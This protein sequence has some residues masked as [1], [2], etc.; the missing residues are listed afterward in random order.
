MSQHHA[1][2][3]PALA[4]RR[5]QRAA[6]PGWRLGL[7]RHRLPLLFLLPA[8]V[9]VAAVS[10]YPIL[11]AIYVS[12]HETSYLRLT[13]F[14]GLKHYVDFVQDPAGQNNLLRSFIYVLGSLVL[15]MPL[16]VSVAILLNRRLRFRTL[17]RTVVVIPWVIAQ[18][19]AALTWGWLANGQFGPLPFLMQQLLGIRLDL[20]SPQTA[21][22]TLIVANVWQSFPYP[23]LLTLAALQTIP[24]ELREAALVDGANAW[25]RFWRITVPLISNTLLI[26]LIMLTLHNFNMVTLPLV[27]T[28]GG[29]VGTTEGLSVR[30]YLEGFQFNRFGFASAVG[31]AIFGFN[32]LFSLLYLKILRGESQR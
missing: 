22:L 28:G 16:G 13:S 9:L 19:V 7:R 23:M 27:M 6:A 4:R 5:P 21:M 20:L 10:F 29:P 25:A 17:F 30:A 8:V 26:S 15:A 12:L 11:Y 14:V 24:D 3:A 2:Q 1:L 32:M 31:V 18:V